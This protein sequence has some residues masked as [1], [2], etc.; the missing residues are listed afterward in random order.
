MPPGSTLTCPNC[1]TLE[2]AQKLGE[3][4]TALELNLL[5]GPGAPRHA[6]RDTDSLI[7]GASLLR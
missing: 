1:R 3:R 7:H 4:D 5:V 2:E 6:L